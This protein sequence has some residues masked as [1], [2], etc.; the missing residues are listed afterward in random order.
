MRRIIT[1]IVLSFSIFLASCTSKKSYQN[2]RTIET[3]NFINVTTV[4]GW[5][6]QAWSTAIFYNG[7]KVIAKK[8]NSTMNVI[9]PKD[10]ILLV[11]DSV[12]PGTIIGKKCNAKGG[13]MI[14]G[15]Q[16]ILSG[17]N[18]NFMAYNK[19]VQKGVTVEDEN[20]W[21]LGPANGLSVVNCIPKDDINNWIST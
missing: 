5:P 9:C 10:Q 7:I 21:I 3:P 18:A 15:V 14:T 19:T 8:H 12:V 17:G 1:I 11:Q 2:S 16:F 6:N 20:A 13:C 4:L